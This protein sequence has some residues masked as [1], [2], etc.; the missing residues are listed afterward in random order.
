MVTRRQASK[1]ID[2]RER[3]NLNTT[4]VAAPSPIPKSVQ[5]AL[6]EPNWLAAMSD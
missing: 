6:K 1:I 3:L 4:T 2:P 5:G